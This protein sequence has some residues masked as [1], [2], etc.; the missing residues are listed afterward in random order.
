[1]WRRH[2][3]MTLGAALAAPAAHARQVYRISDAER[4]VAAM[5]DGGKIIYWLPAADVGQAQRLGRALRALRAPLNEILT[6]R[7]E[8]FRQA[9]EAAFEDLDVKTVTELD[10]RPDELLRTPPAPGHNRILV[11]GRPP[12]E[13]ASGQRFPAGTF[14]AGSL[15]IFL[16]ATEI[17]L[18]GTV[19]AARVIT[20][21]QARGALPR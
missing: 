17:T 21:A 8:P 12:L 11:G 4:M 13:A 18:I 20:A 16:P 9:A 14:P 7:G 19:T 2:F 3:L 1:M 15:A 5:Q 6:G 10:F